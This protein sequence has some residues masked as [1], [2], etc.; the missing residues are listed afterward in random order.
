MREPPHRDAGDL[1]VRPMT[2]ARV[3]EPPGAGHVEVMFYESARFYRLSRA[4]P[5]FAASL[6]LLE[7]AAATGRQVAIGLASA[8]SDVIVDVRGG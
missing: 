4:N 7:E 6:R 3:R 2:V 8:E 5:S 1:H